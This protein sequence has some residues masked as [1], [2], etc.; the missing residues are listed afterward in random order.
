MRILLIGFMIQNIAK[1]INAPRYDESQMH[2]CVDYMYVHV[3]VHVYNT[4]L[5][6]FTY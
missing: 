4:T 1:H 3:C 2:K 5:Y 6:S